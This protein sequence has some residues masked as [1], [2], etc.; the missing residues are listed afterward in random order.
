[1]HIVGIHGYDSER[2]CYKCIIKFGLLL[3]DLGTAGRKLWTVCGLDVVR[4]WGQF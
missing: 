3:G 1:M 4:N 2:V